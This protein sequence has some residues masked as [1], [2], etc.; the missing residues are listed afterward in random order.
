M[1]LLF[2]YFLIFR[3]IQKASENKIKDQILELIAYLAEF[4][5]YI[6]IEQFFKLFRTI[7]VENYQEG[8]IRFLAKYFENIQKNI[9][10]KQ[11]EA[12]KVLKSI[13]QEN[14]TRKSL[15]K[16]LIEPPK[17]LFEENYDLY[18]YN[19]LWTS[20]NTEK[21]NSGLRSLSME[22]LLKI[23]AKKSEIAEDYLIRATHILVSE[24]TEISTRVFTMKFFKEAVKVSGKQRPIHEILIVL[25][26]EFK[27]FAQIFESFKNYKRQVSSFLCTN[28]NIKPN[29][30][31][32]YVFFLL[33]PKK[34]IYK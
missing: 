23:S 15:G 4:G 28:P 16:P 32:G 22:S 1:D 17:E 26:E 19:L 20:M 29:E 33:I 11:I 14:M 2:K 6:V 25:D 12:V 34:E 5:Q 21:L 10:K 18:D 31:M 9:E 7:P 13:K 3:N 24:K 27:I 8:T 30:I